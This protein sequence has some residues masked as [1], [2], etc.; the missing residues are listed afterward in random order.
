MFFIIITFER[1]S[2][3]HLT[4]KTHVNDRVIVKERNMK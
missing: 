2:F 4:Y 1:V 3:V